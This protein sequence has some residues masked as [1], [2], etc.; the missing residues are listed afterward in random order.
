MLIKSLPLLT[1]SLLLSA[2]GQSADTSNASGSSSSNPGGMNAGSTAL[3]VDIAHATRSSSPQ[4][5]DTAG[6]LYA[7]QE[8]AISTE[9]SGYRIADVLVDVGDSVA[10]GQTLARLDDTLLHQAY[11]QAKAAVAVAQ[12]TADQAQSAAKRGSKLRVDGL[13]SQQDAEELNTTA[14]T[15]AAQLQSAQAALQSAEQRLAYTDI[16]ATDPGVIASRAAAP[17]QIASSGTTLFTLIRD[18]RVEWRAEI[19]ANDI[20]KIKR[21]MSA[22]I[23]RSDGSQGKG[24][25][26]TISPG[27]DASTQR[28]TAYVD[29]KLEPLVR[30]GMYVTGSIELDSSPVL[31]V[32]LSAVTVR[33]GFSYV[34]VLQ[35]DS[36]VRQTRIEVSRLLSDTVEV[37]SGIT[38]DDAIVSSGVGLLRD[39]DRVQ[40]A[41]ATVQS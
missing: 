3:T 41:T 7:W 15:A 24:T 22:S 14:A 17:G 38:T 4:L 12:A 31:S 33:D 16:K 20:G 21:G 32:P 18:S 34:F 19:P 9:V 13:I 26:R 28:G 10:K 11:D 30:P 27:L 6:G 2:C 5:L 8:V 35:D 39:G 25:V 36:S 40:V 1:L 23:L 29:F 37:A